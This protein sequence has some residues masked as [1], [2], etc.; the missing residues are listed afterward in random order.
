[1]SHTLMNLRRVELV[2]LGPGEQPAAVGKGAAKPAVPDG[3]PPTVTGL[4]L[5]EAAT[6]RPL[7]ALATGMRIDLGTLPPVSVRAETAG[8]VR[9]VQFVE[10]GQAKHPPESNPPYAI[11]GDANGV[12]VPWKPEPGNRTVVVVPFSEAGGRGEMGKQLKMKFRVLSTAP[13]EL[14]IREAALHGDGFR[15]EWV[16]DP[17][18]TGWTRE[19]DWLDWEFRVAATANYKVELLYSCPPGGGGEFVLRAGDTRT[20]ATA[21]PTGPGGTD[22]FH[23][24]TVAT[25]PLVKGSRGRIA[26]KPAELKG[27]EKPLMNLRAVRLTPVPSDDKGGDDDDDK[28]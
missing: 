1:L 6:G 23:W 16:R 4:T 27:P 24:V 19:Q 21:A 13:I 7:C 26:I 10:E 15:L 25:A 14:G 17:T 8:R 22:G 28:E 12:Y 20:T 3:G 18:L 9:S 2:P 11:A 5:V